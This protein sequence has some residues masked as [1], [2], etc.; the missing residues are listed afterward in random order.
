MSEARERPG[1]HGAID[2]DELGGSLINAASKVIRMPVAM[3]VFGGK[4]DILSSRLD[5]RF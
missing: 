1:R 2:S 4:A 5:V 3:S